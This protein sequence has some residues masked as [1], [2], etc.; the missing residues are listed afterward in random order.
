MFALAKTFQHVQVV[1]NTSL[2]YMKDTVAD[3]GGEE[4]DVSRLN[5]L[6]WD[7]SRLN[8]LVRHVSSPGDLV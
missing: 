1:R 6:V 3:R 4:R 2:P 5:D 8:D 7:V